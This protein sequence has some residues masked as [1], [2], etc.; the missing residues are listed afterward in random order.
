MR[1][2]KREEEKK[3]A[4]NVKKHEYYWLRLQY[5]AEH[6]RK[7]S[8]ARK[9]YQVMQSFP[10]KN[11]HTHARAHNNNKNN[12]TKNNLPLLDR[13]SLH[14]FSAAASTFRS[15]SHLLRSLFTF[16]THFFPQSAC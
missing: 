8:L 10:A 14:A 6:S 9:W 13:A 12:D 3:K 16:S 11:E 7:V 5:H 1:D 4:C 15:L 2:D